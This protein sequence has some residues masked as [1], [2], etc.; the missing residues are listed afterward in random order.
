MGTAIAACKSIVV[1]K[2][3][4]HCYISMQVCYYNIVIVKD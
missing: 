4:E 1:I 3:I 2:S